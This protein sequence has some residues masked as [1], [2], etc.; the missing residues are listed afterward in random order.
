MMVQCWLRMRN[1]TSMTPPGPCKTE[2]DRFSIDVMMS[3]LDQASALRVQCTGVQWT[4]MAQVCFVPSCIK[5]VGLNWDNVGF[6][7]QFT[8]APPPTPTPYL[9]ARGCVCVCA[10][11]CGWVWV[12]VGGCFTIFTRLVALHHSWGTPEACH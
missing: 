5:E 11:V 9:C 6:G 12:W 2:D 8:Q 3:I 7:G 1:K 4:N 10:R